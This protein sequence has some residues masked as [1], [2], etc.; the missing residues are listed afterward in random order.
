ME[1]FR[2]YPPLDG[3]GGIRLGIFRVMEPVNGL[4][5]LQRNP[6]WPPRIDKTAICAQHSLLALATLWIARAVKMN[7]LTRHWINSLKMKNR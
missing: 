4:C 1:M 3:Q 5:S 6:V 2:K 7:M